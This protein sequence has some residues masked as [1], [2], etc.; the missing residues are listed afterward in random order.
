M[1]EQM[2][3]EQLAQYMKLKHPDIMFR[4]DMAGVRLTMLQAIKAKKV[5]GGRAWPDIQIVAMRGRFGSLFLE[6][7]RPG[8][9]IFL[10][11]GSLSKNM[12][13]REQATVLHALRSAGYAA[14]FAIGIDDAIAHVEAYLG[15]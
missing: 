5:Q 9:R 12:H 3:Q 11:D 1:T 7:K 10:K 13:V 14:E 4:S 8:E 6:L 15:L 2:V